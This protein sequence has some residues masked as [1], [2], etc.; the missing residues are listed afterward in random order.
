MNF[1]H[2]FCCLLL[3]Q[4]CPFVILAH[5]IFGTRSVDREDGSPTLDTHV[6][7]LFACMKPGARMITLHP[8]ICLGRSITEA[9]YARRKR[10]LKESCDASFFKEETHILKGPAVTWTNKDVNIYIYTRIKQSNTIKHNAAVFMCD[11]PSCTWKSPTLAVG[12]DGMLQD[13]CIYCDAK[14]NITT[15]KRI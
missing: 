14:R 13:I 9:N 2:S 10:K 8:L 1:E 4:K 12:E 7:S 11:N 3:S 15:R 6:G 5:D